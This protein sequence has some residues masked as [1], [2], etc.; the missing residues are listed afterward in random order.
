MADLVVEAVGKAETFN[1]ATELV[2]DY[3][4]IALFG[5]PKAPVLP[6]AVEA[7]LRRNVR[8]IASAYAQREPGL[9]SFRLAL[10]LMAQGRLDPSI[11]VT[12]RLPFGEIRRGLQLAESKEAGAVKVLL[13]Y[14]I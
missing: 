5:V 10:N 7:L 2:R 8:L 13:D 11:L 3:G 6:I 1:L 4:T 12:H 9:A 14:S